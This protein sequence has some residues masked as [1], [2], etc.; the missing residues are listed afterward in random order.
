MNPI[1]TSSISHVSSVVVLELSDEEFVQF[2]GDW[3]KLRSTFTDKFLSKTQ[4]EWTE[5]FDGT[6]AC[7]T[8]VVDLEL[9]QHHPHNHQVCASNA[10]LYNSIA[11]GL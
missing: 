8:P 5:I 7:V 1:K 9:A 11:F 2:G 3:A 6:D 10:Y 4:A